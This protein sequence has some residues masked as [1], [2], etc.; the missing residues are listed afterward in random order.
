MA[1]A[2]QYFG[3]EL[4]IKSKMVG[5][6]NSISHGSAAKPRRVHRLERRKSG[7]LFGATNSYAKAWSRPPNKQ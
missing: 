2:L 7:A 4:D 1:T 3:A 5:M 6:K